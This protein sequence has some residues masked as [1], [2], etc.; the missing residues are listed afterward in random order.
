MSSHLRLSF[1]EHASLC[2]VDRK[3]GGTEVQED[4]VTVT[5]RGV[6]HATLHDAMHAECEKATGEWVFSK[7]GN[8]GLSSALKQPPSLKIQE[9]SPA[10]HTEAMPAGY[11]S[12]SRLQV[13]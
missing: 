4:A 12:H 1:P 10:G 11:S 5:P 2:P 8:P 3:S 13:R 7:R 6:V 9:V